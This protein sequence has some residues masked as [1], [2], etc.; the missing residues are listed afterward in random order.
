M[1]RLVVTRLLAAIPTLFAVVALAFFMMRLAPGGPFDQ[2]RAL[3]PATRATLDH[4][5]GFDKPLLV[6]FGLYLDALAHG[7]LGPSTHWRDFTVN[8][9]FAHALPISIRLG[10]QALVLALVVGVA[11]GL[12]GAGRRG[13]RTLAI[14]L[15]ALVGLAVP[16]FV[17]APLLQVWLGLDARLLPVGGWGDG[18]LS[19]QVLPVLTLAL[20]QIAI[21]AKL[22]AAATRDALAAPHIRTLRA[23]GLPGWH[24]GLHALRGALLPVLSYCGPAAAA[25]LT[26]SLVV[27]KIFGIP[28]IGRY[29]VDGALAR[30][31]TLTMATVVVVGAMIVVFN[32]AVDLAYGVLD[33]RV[34]HG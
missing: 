11:L 9:L 22:T 13:L 10:T 19:H 23:F 34:R 18:A 21:V 32:L 15:L 17:I 6:Q 7:D 27:E 2:E 16:P 20:P 31:Y 14:A 3:D 29:F 8:E 28:G 1:L 12:A 33:P 26:G 30:D 5:Y 25:L 4:M 24:I